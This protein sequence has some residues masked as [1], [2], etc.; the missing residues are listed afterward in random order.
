MDYTCGMFQLFWFYRADKQTH[1]DIQ[2]TQTDADERFTP[3]TH[4]E[5]RNDCSA[6]WH[7]GHK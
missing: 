1:K 7:R 5:V 3:A 6:S 2:I 4:V